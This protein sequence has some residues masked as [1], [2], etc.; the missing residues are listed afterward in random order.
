MEEFD[1]CII[2]TSTN[3]DTTSSRIKVEGGYAYTPDTPGLGMKG[4][5][6][7]IGVRQIADVQIKSPNSTGTCVKSIQSLKEKP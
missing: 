7:V 1:P 5:W 6:P 3:C 2:Q 4:D